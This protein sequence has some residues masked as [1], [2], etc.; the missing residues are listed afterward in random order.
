[1]LWR[2]SDKWQLSKLNASD[3]KAHAFLLRTPETIVMI[4]AAVIY[5]PGGPEVLK[6]ETVPVPTPKDGEVLTYVKASGLNRS[7]LFTSQGHS[8]S[9]KLPR[10]LVLK[11][12]AWS[13]SRPAASSAMVRLLREQ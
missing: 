5:E 12:A 6:L 7:E 11:R 3:R 4:N 8:P 9:V 2:R 13:R 1:M 10:V